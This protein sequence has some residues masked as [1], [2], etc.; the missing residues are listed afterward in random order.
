[1]KTSTTRRVALAS[2]AVVLLAAWW[3]PLPEWAFGPF[4]SRML[5]HLAM[6]AVAAPL[7]GYWLAGTRLRQSAAAPLFPPLAAA[8][9]ELI[10]VWLWH[11]PLL[12]GLARFSGGVGWLEQSSLLAAALLLW[13][14]ALESSRRGDQGARIL[15]LLVTS[16][17]LMLLG[18]VLTLASRPLYGHGIQTLSDV[19][20]QLAG[21]RQGGM[22]ML[23][24]G[25]T[26]WLVAALWLV[27]R[28]RDRLPANA[29]LHARAGA[30][31]GR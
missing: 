8:A 16:M 10:V 6:I 27:D 26:H 18:T 28:L 20:A 4:A 9:I 30:R 14:S 24:G 19:Y 31:S 17:H 13:T 1:M 15:A 12:H 3:S 25:V 29:A 7:I 23:I 5:V 11:L 22:L 21:Q 2:G